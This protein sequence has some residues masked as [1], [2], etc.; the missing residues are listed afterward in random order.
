MDDVASNLWQALGSGGGKKGGGRRARAEVE[1]EEEE[2][3]GEEPLA[4]PEWV[5]ASRAL[6]VWP[7]RC[8]SPSHQ[9]N[10]EPSFIELNGTV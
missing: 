6:A 3:G 2:G 1:A 10:F 9:T 4:T 8:C 7:A 5:A